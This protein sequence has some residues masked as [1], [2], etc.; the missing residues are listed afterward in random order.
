[1]WFQ[2]SF[3]NNFNS[4]IITEFHYNTS[5]AILKGYLLHLIEYFDF[6]GYKFLHI[7]EMV[8]K[9]VSDRRYRAFES[10]KSVSWSGGGLEDPL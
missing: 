2:I 6:R 3:F 7:D 1:M 8:I 10:S 4:H 5:I 9:T